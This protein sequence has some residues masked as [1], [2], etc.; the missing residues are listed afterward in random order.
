MQ[1]RHKN[2]KVSI[3]DRFLYNNVYKKNNLS[4]YRKMFT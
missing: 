2:S 1:A 3:S 4:A